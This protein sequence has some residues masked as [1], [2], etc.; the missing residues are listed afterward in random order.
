MLFF[1]IALKCPENAEYTLCMEECAPTCNDPNGNQCSPTGVCT[2]GCHCLEG[3][4]FSD[5]QCV[6]PEECGCVDD[7][8]GASVAVSI[9][10]AH[11]RY[12]R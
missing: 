7:Q 1:I 5:G 11:I 4:V 12:K 2:E 9:I 6:K 10:I 8:T 3:F